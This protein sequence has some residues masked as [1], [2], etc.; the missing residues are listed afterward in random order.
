MQ[1]LLPAREFFIRRISFVIFLIIF[2][3]FLFFRGISDFLA[4]SPTID[5]NDG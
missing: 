1:Q 3:L 2:M 4:L 5:G